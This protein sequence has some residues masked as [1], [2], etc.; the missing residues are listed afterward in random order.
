MYSSFKSNK[1]SIVHV[2][3]ALVCMLTLV[4]IVLL[5]A[6]PVCIYKKVVNFLSEI[7]RIVIN[8]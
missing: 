2:F 4:F 3:I 6:L 7:V 8:G 1:I 5:V